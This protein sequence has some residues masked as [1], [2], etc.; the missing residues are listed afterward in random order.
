MRAYR[1]SNTNQG[2]NILTLAEYQNI[3]E[4]D[5]SSHVLYIIAVDGATAGTVT[6]SA[7]YVGTVAQSFL[8]NNQ[9]ALVWVGDQVPSAQVPV[10]ITGFT[11]A[12]VP[13]AD[14]V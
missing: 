2:V 11:N 10:A 12:D 7:V 3:P 14:L 6:I 1:E 5:R 8:I 4:N 13:I 9:G